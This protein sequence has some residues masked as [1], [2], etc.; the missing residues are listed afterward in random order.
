M[1]PFIIISACK[2]EE[3][4]TKEIDIP[5]W[6]QEEIDM[7]EKELEDDPNSY[8][9]YGAWM[10]YK[11]NDQYFFEYENMLSSYS[12]GSIMYDYDGVVY[13]DNDLPNTDA[14]VLSDYDDLKC[15][16]EYVWKG[17]NHFELSSYN[18]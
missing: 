3:D 14:A 5:L 2:K 6:L 10:R 16:M 17:E 8:N 7:Y 4:V 13:Y 1:F 11:Y 9:S 18:P 12:W 15:C